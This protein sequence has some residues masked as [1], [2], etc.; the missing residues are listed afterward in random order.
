MTKYITYLNEN[1]LKIRSLSR[2]VT[3]TKSISVVMRFGRQGTGR[4]YTIIERRQARD[5]TIT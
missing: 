2:A 4:L 1:V 3:L 5:V